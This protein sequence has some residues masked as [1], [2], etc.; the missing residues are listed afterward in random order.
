MTI[1]RLDHMSVVVEDLAA[2]IERAVRAGRDS[3]P[4]HPVDVLWRSY[5]SSLSR[6][7]P[8]SQV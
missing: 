3:Q 6:T 8:H 4:D 2:A 7:S 1:K 5:V